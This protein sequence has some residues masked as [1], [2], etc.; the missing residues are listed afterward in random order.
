MKYTFPLPIAMKPCLAV[1][2]LLALPVVAAEAPAALNEMK[3]LHQQRKWTEFLQRYATESF[4]TWAPEATRE[5]LQI[6]GQIY[7]FTKD[8]KHAEADLQAAL[9]LA[10]HGTD[11]MLLLAENYVNNLNDDAKAISA[12]QQVIAITGTNQGWQPLT[13]TVGLARLYTDQVKLAAALE[14]LKPY[15]DLSQLPNT[16]RIKLLR[17]Y[18]HIYAAQGKE[19]ESLAKFREALRLESQP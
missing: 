4:A 17:A 6:R 14:V 2:C 5:A 11:I 7:S 16:W 8:G 13:A 1:L 15:G 9:K 19:P 12:Y 3:T 18:G 10:P